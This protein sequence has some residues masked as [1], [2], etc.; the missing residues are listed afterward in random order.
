MGVP[1]T[2]AKQF[3]NAIGMTEQLLKQQDFFEHAD[4]Q[5][6]YYQSLEDMDALIERLAIEL[7]ALRERIQRTREDRSARA[8]ADQAAAQADPHGGLEP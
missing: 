6:A 5:D 7:S 4:K 8:A 1:L 2:V 3:C